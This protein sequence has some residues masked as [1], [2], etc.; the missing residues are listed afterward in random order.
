MYLLVLI[1]PSRYYRCELPLLRYSRES[2]A[3]IGCV[4][5]QWI[6]VQ[7]VNREA[8]AQALPARLFTAIAKHGFRFREVLIID[9]E[10]MTKYS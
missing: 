5:T 9:V 4:V 8:E 2:W 3:Q 1:R 7:A 10:Y 6:L